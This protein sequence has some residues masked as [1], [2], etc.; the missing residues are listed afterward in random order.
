M[1]RIRLPLFL[2]ELLNSLPELEREDK[3]KMQD[4]PDLSRN[5]KELPAE[6]G[7]FPAQAVRALLAE[8]GLPRFHGDT[9]ARRGETLLV[10]QS[11]SS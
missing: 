6:G 4:S 2:F 9:S 8:R 10:R 1:R 3:R 11:S 7:R 5:K